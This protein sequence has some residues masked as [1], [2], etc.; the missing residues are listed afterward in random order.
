MV[1]LRQL[2]G[3][4]Y[5]AINLLVIQSVHAKNTVHLCGISSTGISDKRARTYPFYCNALQTL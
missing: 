5:F 3:E 2:E 4:K 1:S